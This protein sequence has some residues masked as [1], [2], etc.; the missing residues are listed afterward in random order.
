[1]TSGRSWTRRAAGGLWSRVTWRAVRLPWCSRRR[2]RN[3]SSRWCCWAG[4]RGRCAEPATRGVGQAH[5]GQIT[6]LILAYWGAG[7]DLD[8][9]NPGMAGDEEFRRWY[10]QIQRM[11]ASPA[12]AAA[13]AR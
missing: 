2:I 12:T 11:S 5:V 13:M 4:M 1:M 3:G 6:D 8:F 10:A 9:T 7:A